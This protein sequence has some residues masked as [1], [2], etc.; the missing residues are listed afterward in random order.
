MRTL[1]AAGSGGT[2][3]VRR[4]DAIRPLPDVQRPR[5]TERILDPCECITAFVDG[6]VRPQV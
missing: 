1:T 2:D 3:D 4:I 5:N 6:T